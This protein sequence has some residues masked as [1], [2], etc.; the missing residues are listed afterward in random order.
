MENFDTVGEY[1]TEENGATIDASG[2]FD[3]TKFTGTSG[4]GKAIH[5]HPQAAV[6]VAN[7]L[8]EYASGHPVAKEDAEFNKYLQQQFAASGYKVPA[9]MRTIVT[10]P[11]FYRIS[12]PGT[13]A[14]GVNL[15]SADTTPRQEASK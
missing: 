2:E 3:G 15:S 14:G 5:D 10:T 11:A 9:L 1:R 6:C 8:F 7:R 13:E 4:L 12:T